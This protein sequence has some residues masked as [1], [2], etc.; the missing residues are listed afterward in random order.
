MILISAGFPAG[1]VVSA[2]GAMATDAAL[3]VESDPAGA[4][5][6]VDG[7]PQ[8]ATPIQLPRL[9]PGDHRV[10]LTKPGYLENSRV[11]TLHAGRTQ[12]LHVRL[13]AQAAPAAEK[14]PA[15]EPQAQPESEKK[16]GG[17]KKWVLLGLGLAGA[18]AATYVVVTKNDPPVPGTVTVSPSGTGMASATSYTFTS[19]ATDPDNDALT[20]EWNFGDGATGSGQTATHVFNS[21]GTF[22][23]ALSVKDSK[24]TVTAPSASVIVARNMAGTWT[25]GRECGFGSTV[26]L[27]LAQSGNS[28]GGTWVFTGG[29][30]GSL[31]L[32]GNIGTLGYPTSVTFTTTNFT[33]GNL[34]GTFR[35]S[36][37]GTVD[38][39]G[40][41]M[42]GTMT[43][44]STD[45]QPPSF[46]CPSSF[47]R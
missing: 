29:L 39:S 18:G 22:S 19:N 37:A 3:S 10:S 16:G 5:I 33:V 20:Y 27:N 35:V 14:P 25:G 44:T 4:T 8:G 32:S 13:T 21:A 42:N 34:P 41:A 30:Q 9:T 7:Q 47:Q 17:S 11:V 23:V 31:S 1:H 6:Y 24:H 2:A 38:A 12:G 15:R 40:N 36:F 46:T 45:L 26:T 43:S 28:L